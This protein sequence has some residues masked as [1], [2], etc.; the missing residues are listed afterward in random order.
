MLDAQANAEALEEQAKFDDLEEEEEA[1]VEEASVEAAPVEAASV[2]EAPIEGVPNA[3]MAA[4]VLDPGLGAPAPVDK[5]V[6]IL[7]PA[8]PKTPAVVEK[9]AAPAEE[10]AAPAPAIYGAPSYYTPPSFYGAPY[11]Q[12]YY[13]RYQPHP[14]YGRYHGVSVEPLKEEPKPAAEV[15]AD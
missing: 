15:P 13:P 9:V 10:E 14:E 12:P 11:N 8:E 6:P 3:V 1:P 5:E 2:E 4:E 7:V